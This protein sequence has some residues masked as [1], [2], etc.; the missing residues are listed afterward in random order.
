MKKLHVVYKTHLDIGFTD[1]AQNVIDNY[2]EDFIPRAIRLGNER[3]ETFVWTTGSWLMD[4]YLK[5]PTIAEEKKEDLRE[6]LRAGTIRWHGLATTTHCELMD[7]TLFDYSL[8]L[9]QNLDKKFDKKTIAA[10]LT[11]IPGHTLGIVPLMAKAGLKYLHIGVNASTVVPDIPEMFVW[12][13]K[14]GS[15]I[16]VHY[17]NDYGDAFTR[18]G[19]EEMLYF[20]HSHDNQGPPKSAEEIDEIITKLRAEYPDAEIIPSGLD[21]FAEYAWSK[22]E[23]LPVVEEEIGDTWIHGVGTDPMKVSQ[24]RQLYRLRNQWLANEE[25]TLDSQEYADFSDQLLMVVEHTWGGNGNVFLP[26]YHNYLI[27]DFKKA[28]AKDRIEVKTEGY[29]DYGGV[30]GMVAKNIHPDDLSAKHSYRLMEASWQEQ[31]DYITA[32]IACLTPERQAEV[33]A[34]FAKNDLAITPLVQKEVLNVGYVY[35]LPNA[36]ELSIGLNGGIN[37]LKVKGRELVANGTEFGGL[38]Y[39]RF[40]EGNYQQFMNNYCRL[41]RHTAT[42]ALVD[43][44]KGGIEAY[45]D[46]FH[47]IIKPMVEKGTIQITEEK[48]EITIDAVYKAS[49]IKNWGLPERNR[50]TY[51]IDTKDGTIDGTYRWE[52]KQA[53]RMPEGY[54]LETS[55]KVNNPYRWKMNKLSYNVSPYDVVSQGN[56][57]L[58]A[59]SFE[60]MNYLG[61]DAKLQI[62]SETAPLVSMGRRGLL[63]FDQA[64]PS[65]NEGIFI[66]LY[67]NTW[68][69]NFPDWFEDDMTFTFS[70]NFDIY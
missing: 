54:W 26:D 67:N 14:D 42:W 19:W 23:T 4:Y 18:E 20:A 10:K 17:A 28:R 46:I 40:D 45:P 56:R 29:L 57:N 7:E 69:T 60:G 62:M 37:Y 50:L 43:Y 25:L 52:G 16:I 13:A 63:T 66:N 48:V 38:S 70:A 9:S 34:S 33:H 58:H 68:G 53:N 24:L 31:R 36:I 32:A 44:N 11:D 3:P 21:D 27:E 8:T 6:A 47:E 35:E 65:L 2:V 64:Q 22:K 12:R 39:E 59:L 49:D 61:S 41:S 1:L 5:L 15:E 30:L 51:V 55:L